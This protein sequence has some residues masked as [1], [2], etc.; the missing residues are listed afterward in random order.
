MMCT[1]QTP[2]RLRHAMCIGDIEGKPF[3]VAKIA[4]RALAVPSD[5]AINLKTA[6]ALGLEVPSHLLALADD[7]IE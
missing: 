7:V 1:A 2:C 5:G 3:C 4:P 6:K